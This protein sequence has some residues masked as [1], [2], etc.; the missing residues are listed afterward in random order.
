MKTSTVIA[1]A[2]MLESSAWA[3]TKPGRQKVVVCIE[4]DGQVAVA[5]AMARASR[6]FKPAGVKLDWHSGLSVCQ[7]EGDQ[8][9]MVSLSTSTSTALHP[10]ALACAFVYKGEHIQVFYDR[11]ALS[12]SGDLLSYVLAHVFVHEI[13]HILQGIDR[14][15]NSGIMKAFWSPDDCTLM[16]TGQLRFTAW[17]IE[18]IHDGLAVRAARLGTLV[19]AVAP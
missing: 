12:Y 19:G 16:K 2:A 17:D 5:D 13:A 7:G 1:I 15:S 18:L 11:I 8:A 4:G 3:A 14:H 10:G 6:V 9:I